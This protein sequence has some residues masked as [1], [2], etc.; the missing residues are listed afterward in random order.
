MA[1][2][3]VSVLRAPTPRPRI[4]VTADASEEAIA[5]LGELG[6]VE[7]ASFRETMRLLTG[8]TLAEALREVEVFVSEIDVVDASVIQKSPD[9]RIIAACRGDAVN[10]DLAACTAFGIPVLHSPGRNADAV[11]DLALAFFLMLARQLPTATAFLRQPGIEAGDMGRMGQ[12]FTS[13]RGRE[14][15]RKTIGLV[16]LGAVGRGV[17]RRVAAFGARVLV[18]DPYLQDEQVRQAEV[19]RVSLGDLLQRSDFVSLHAAVTGETK[20]MVGAAELAQMKPGAFLVNT[21][22]AALIDEAALVESLRSGH[23]GGAALDVFSVEPPGSDHPLLAF[24]NVIVTPHVGGNTEEVATHQGLIIAEDLRRLLQG[25]SP[26][27]VLNGDVVAQFDWT[28]PRRQ[29]DAQTLAELFKRPAPAVS[30]L[31]RD[32]APRSKAP[33]AETSGSAVMLPSET[34]QQMQ[35]ILRAFVDHICADEAMRE[36]AVDKDVTLRFIV[37]DADATFFLRLQNGLVLGDLTPPEP[38]ADVELKMPADVLDGMFTDR[39]NP[40]QAATSGG[41]SFSGDT[42]KAMTL[43][44]IQRDLSRLYGAARS[45]VGDLHPVVDGDVRKSLVDVVNELFAVQLITATGGNV[46]VRVP[47]SEDELWITPSQLFKGDLKAEIL[48]RINLDGKSLDPGALS[49]SSERLMHCAVY[50]ARADAQAVIHAHAPHAT[51]LANAGLPF[52]P[53]STEAAF[54]GNIPRIPF[55]MPGTQLLA[56]AIA[57]AVSNSWAVLM[58]NHG[59]LVAGRSLR[60]AA[61]MVEIVERSAEII[62]GC[63]AVGKEPPQLPDDIVAKLRKMGDLLA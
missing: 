37:P 42:V 14:L 38:P 16:G 4:L 32:A 29:P 25:H 26:H 7:Y 8:S 39:I 36:F 60:R 35:R 22:R 31:Q 56:D 13:L 20:G 53:I 3:E 27:H 24:D 6:D 52:L 15:W 63:Y 51:I 46:S 49:P 40:M 19:E 58:Q 2:R 44:E 9:L 50:R 34:R 55:I 5:A 30:D 54:F 18:Y 43:Q 47:G 61:D 62:L 23:L 41:L 45:D 33:A 21:A 48:V 10:V 11:A 17:A 1:K 59:L 28:T 12:A 57:E